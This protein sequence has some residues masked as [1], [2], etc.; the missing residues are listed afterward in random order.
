MQGGEGKLKH[1]SCFIQNCYLIENSKMN[2][3]ITCCLHD[4]LGPEAQSHV[5]NVEQGRKDMSSL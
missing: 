2:L 5:G 3:T 4:G 1:C